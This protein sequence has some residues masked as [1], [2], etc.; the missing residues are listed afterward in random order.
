MT[1]TLTRRTLPIVAAAALAV[2]ALASTATATPAD[3]TA[4]SVGPG[5][6]EQEYVACLEGAPTSADSRE[7]W[8]LSCREQATAGRA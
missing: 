6:D 1:S 3:D 8:V 4:G 5:L 7:R 2:S